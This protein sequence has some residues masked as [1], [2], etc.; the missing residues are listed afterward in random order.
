MYATL[1]IF[2]IATENKLEQCNAMEFSKI[3]HLEIYNDLPC[4]GWHKK[5]KPLT[6]QTY[7]VDTSWI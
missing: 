4:T 7:M 5:A 2:S 3:T 6:L 1:A